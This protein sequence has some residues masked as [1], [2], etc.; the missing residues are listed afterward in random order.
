MAL[1]AFLPAVL[2]GIAPARAETTRSDAHGTVFYLDGAGGG[3]LI[4][5]WSSGVRKGLHEG[6]Y[7]GEFREE[8]WQTGLG[9]GADHFA[10]AS[11]KRRQASRIAAA[12]RDHIDRH[13]G[14]PVNLIALSSGTVVAIFI[15]EAL[16]TNYQVDNVVLL[17][18]S[19]SSQ[20]DLTAAL[21]HVRGRLYVFTSRTDAVLEVLV[22]LTGTADRRFS[23]P[24]GTVGL[25][26]PS[27]AGIETHELYAKV[28]NIP[29]RRSFADSG[30]FGDHVGPARRRFVRDYVAPLLLHP[31]PAPGPIAADRPPLLSGH[32]VS[33]RPAPAKPSSGRSR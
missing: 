22:P 25:Q 11:F 31:L 9:P 1:L 5:S 10:S 20:H 4:L 13:P 33:S 26:P 32:P 23:Q 14:E 18:A 29:W 30:N 17:S 2:A 24:A 19:I 6:G 16:P 12:I 3:G 8:S 21:R 28:A 7:R 27:D 15:L